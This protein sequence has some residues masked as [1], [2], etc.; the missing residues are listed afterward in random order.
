MSGYVFLKKAG[1]GYTSG[2]KGQMG[3]GENDVV[4]S[5]EVET[6]C[7]SADLTTTA[8]ENRLACRLLTL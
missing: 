7:L 1:Y 5:T 4:V 8:L 6:P 2:D 3:S